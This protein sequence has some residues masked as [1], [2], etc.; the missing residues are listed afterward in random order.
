MNP[1]RMVLGDQRV[2]GAGDLADA[3]DDHVEVVRHVA[4]R[5]QDVAERDIAN[6]RTAYGASPENRSANL[7]DESSALA[8]SY[9]A[10]RPAIR[11]EP[12]PRQEKLGYRES[13]DR[14]AIV[15][16]GS[17]VRAAPRRADRLLLPNARLVVRGRGRRAGD[18]RACVACVRPVRG[19]LVVALVALQ[20]RNQRLPRH[21]EGSQAACAAGRSRRFVA[22]RRS[23]GC[24]PPRE[25]MDPA[26]PRRPGAAG[27]R[28]PGRGCRLSR[29]DPAR[30]RQRVAASPAAPAR[31]VDPARGPALEGQ[32]S[33]GAARNDGRLREQR[34]AA[35]AHDARELEPRSQ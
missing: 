20:H 32:R 27:D 13:H 21:A 4:G 35:G 19:P 8:R 33:R 10:G 6:R 29:V 5:G 23:G 2:V 22:G 11:D 3:A 12:S 34:V 14:S 30:V 28:R 24:D 18:A 17:R 26:D 16:P 25:H 9:R 1:P 31:G 7:R 15:R